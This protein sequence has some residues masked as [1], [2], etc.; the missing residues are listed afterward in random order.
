M[1]FRA[2][3]WFQGV[4][5]VILP[6]LL[7]FSRHADAQVKTA[8]VVDMTTDCTGAA[9][10]DATVTIRS[11]GTND[12][13]SVQTDKGGNYLFNLLPVGRYTVPS[14]CKIVER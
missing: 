1:S 2:G 13:R 5:L 7:L 9:I 11:L 12:E 14:Y 3:F 6:M 10:A 4:I 8:D